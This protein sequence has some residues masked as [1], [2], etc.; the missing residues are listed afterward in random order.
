[1][2]ASQKYA[3]EHFDEVASLVD[4]GE[5]VEIAR[6]DKQV[7]HLVRPEIS[8]MPEPSG[9]RVL[10]AGRGEMRVPSDIEWEEMD[11]GW[12]KS[13]EDKFGPDPS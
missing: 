3:L 6:P 2:K 10:G 4:G 11:K 1:M 7:L 9:P 12:R 13:F 8:A 5:V